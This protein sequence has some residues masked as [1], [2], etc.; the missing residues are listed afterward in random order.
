MLK[1]LLAEDEIIVRLGI[2]AVIAWEKHGFQFVGDA[3][4]GQEAMALIERENPDI[5]LTDIMM[6]NMDGLALIEAVKIKYPHI[7]ILVLS[8]YDEY[9]FVRKA[10]KLGAEDYVLKA[11]LGPQQLLQILSE[12]AL[13]IAK[14]R[15]GGDLNPQIAVSDSEG[16][17]MARIF[18]K[19]LH[20]EAGSGI[21][22]EEEKMARAV[23]Q[24]NN[25]LMHVHL[26]ACGPHRAKPSGSLTL[27]HLLDMHL[28][29]WTNG[30]SVTIDDGESILVLP[31]DEPQNVD[32][33]GSIGRDLITAAK[34]VLDASLSIGVSQS[35][36]EPYEIKTAYEQT[37]TAL[38]NYF[39]QGKEMTY[40]SLAHDRGQQE[41][42]VILFSGEDEKKLRSELERG[43]EGG[44]QDAVFVVLER[45][46]KA[47]LPIGHNIQACLQMLHCFLTAASFLG[48]DALQKPENEKP[49]Y[50]QVINF[51]TWE[52]AREWFKEL[53]VRYCRA[54]REAV[55]EG[56]RE[57]I[58][59]LIDY[60]KENY[61]SNLSLKQAAQMINISEGYL[62]SLFKKVTGIGLIEYVNRVRIEKAAE[63]L[64]ETGLPSYIIAENVGYE[65]VNY[66]S[67]IFKK[68]SG[69]NPKEYRAQHTGIGV[70]TKESVK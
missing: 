66:F 30:L 55:K 50:N 54:V 1:V 43:D 69:L 53:I 68:M 15:S 12:I 10:M 19:F 33:L 35:F 18:R 25:Y 58:R 52:E 40:I 42:G 9:D 13:S 70:A 6:P 34:S 23:L 49:L 24:A 27:L 36:T 37:R 63:L 7:R 56:R 48:G 2:K 57:D 32:V 38:Q 62:S 61:K 59:F 5:L 45:M 4:D 8:S 67:R 11:S 65:N 17:A 28:R 39:L 51:E 14:E 41:S 60:I 31:F 26:H 20:I 44:I 3:A 46:K 22:F 47:G 64:R 21:S 29:K 16:H